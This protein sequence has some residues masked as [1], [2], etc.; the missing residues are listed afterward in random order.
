[1]TARQIVA[2]VGQYPWH[3]TVL[4]IILPLVSGLIGLIHGRDRGGLSPWKYVYAVLVY[5]ACI[6]GML[7]AVLT[8]Y[9]LFFT[10]Q[11]MLDVN[12]LVYIAP[13]IS[14]AATLIAIGKNVSFE[15]VPGFDRVTGLMV[16]L[17]VTFVLMLGLERTRIWLFFGS[18]IFALIAIVAV[19]F[20][21][22]KWAAHMLFR[23]KSEPRIK[24][25]S[26]D[27]K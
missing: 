9:I 12:L 19:L 6:P 24:P 18:S 25:R 17:G 13:I 1:M 4:F 11:N 5:A 15:E 22:L 8:G 10:R 23:S 21:L 27:L 2:W 7:A 26:F 3:L 16:L 14:M 20:A